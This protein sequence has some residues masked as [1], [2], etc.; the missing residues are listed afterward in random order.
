MP[1]DPVRR[2]PR[3][4]RRA[5]GQP[6]DTRLF[7]VA[8][9][10]TYAPK[11]Y[12]G[13]FE[14]ARV[15][16]HVVPTEDGTSAAPHVLNRLLG[17][18]HEENDERWMLL[19]TD[20]CT[21]GSHYPTFI[22]AISEA[23]QR[24]VRVCLSKPCFEFWL[25]LH[26]HEAA[27]LAHVSN[28]RD[29]E[30]TLRRTLGQYDKTNLRPE[31]YALDRVRAACLRARELDATVGGGDRPQANTTRVFQL[32]ASIVASAAVAELPEEFRDL[33]P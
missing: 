27:Q 23:R 16:V 14:I 32:W 19:D 5:A 4:L 28:A 25:L 26:H 13:F 18:H 15:Q 24:G 31:H 11:Q 8:C 9:D 2:Q 20:H 6:R 29:A 33:V 21:I 22:S 10:D 3:P 17:Y 7:I 12:F 1:D 30:E